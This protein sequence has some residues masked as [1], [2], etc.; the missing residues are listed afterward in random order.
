MSGSIV[1]NTILEREGIKAGTFAKVIGVT[2]TQIYDLQN[3]K[4][5]NVTGRIAKKILKAY[6]HYMYA[7]LLS[8]DG[9]ITKDEAA[10]EVNYED[11][12]FA[13]QPE[14]VKLKLSLSEAM[15]AQEKEEI[16][17]QWANVKHQIVNRYL[18]PPTTS[19][20]AVVE[21]LKVAVPEAKNV[22]SS[23]ILQ[24]LFET[25][26]TKALWV[27]TGND[28]KVVVDKL[29]MEALVGQIKALKMLNESQSK[30]IEALRAQSTGKAKHF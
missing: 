19:P 25:N 9:D 13:K 22:R 10:R 23:I 27:A 4:I 26:P 28:D 20:K 18:T 17:N 24:H 14:K 7:W 8:G 16:N 21:R 1:I 11:K 12:D 30:E 29:E 3:G 15:K 6:P 2:P 5:K